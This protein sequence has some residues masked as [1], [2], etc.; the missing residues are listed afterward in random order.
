[1]LDWIPNRDSTSHSSWGWDFYGLPTV[2]G[3][4]TNVCG[5]AHNFT[6]NFVFG[7]WIQRVISGCKKV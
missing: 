7:A 3:Y 6:Y 5:T 2:F 4:C 1:M